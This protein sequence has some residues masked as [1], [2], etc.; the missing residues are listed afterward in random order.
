MAYL[1]SFIHRRKLSR[2]STRLNIQEGQLIILVF[3]L[4]IFSQADTLMSNIRTVALPILV[5]NIAF[6]SVG[7]ISTK[8]ASLPPA[9][10]LATTIE[11]VV[12]Q[13]GPAI[14]IAVGVLHNNTIALPLLLN[15]FISVPLCALYLLY[16]KCNHLSAARQ[17][18]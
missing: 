16:K 2:N 18:P 12:R 9:D 1:L 15:G 8:F 17:N 14:Y 13:E 10:S 7:I 6:L 4:I 5:L 3:A 11:H